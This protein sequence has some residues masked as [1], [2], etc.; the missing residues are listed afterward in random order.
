M[1][2]DDRK[3]F[4]TTLPGML[5]GVAALMVA[6]TTLYFGLRD[7]AAKSEAAAVPAGAAALAAP[8]AAAKTAVAQTPPAATPTV[9]VEVRR[10]QAE[11]LAGDWLAAMGDHDIGR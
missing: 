3:A 8:T 6:S 1:A 9:S 2:D 5:S 7:R 11:R 10:Q 4:F